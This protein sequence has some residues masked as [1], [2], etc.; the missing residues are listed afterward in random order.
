MAAARANGVAARARSTSSRCCGRLRRSAEHPLR[1]LRGGDDAIP[2]TN[3]FEVG[4]ENERAILHTAQDLLPEGAV[5]AYQHGGGAGFGSPLLRDPESVKEDVLDEYVSPEAARTK[6]GVVLT[7]S[8]SEY[9]LEVDHEA[10]E[11]LRR[12]LGVDDLTTEAAE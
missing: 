10:T 12:E 7:G 11:A 1:G 8:L 4:S 6:Y 3:R 2:Y 5:I 9:T